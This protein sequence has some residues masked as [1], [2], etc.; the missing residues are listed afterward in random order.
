M[1]ANLFVFSIGIERYHYIFS[2]TKTVLDQEGLRKA[3]LLLAFALTFVRHS[4]FS[5][6]FLNFETILYCQFSD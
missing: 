3:V 4:S 6:L 5:I 1:A 2:L